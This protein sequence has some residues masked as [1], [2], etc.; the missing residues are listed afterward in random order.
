MRAARMP[1]DA[2]WNDIDH[3]DAHKDFTLDPA[4]FAAGEVA[5]MVADLHAHHQRYVIIV[6]PGIASAAGG[7]DYAPLAA[8][9]RH[10]VFIRDKTGKAP[11]QGRVWPGDVYFPD[12]LHPNASAYWGEQLAA[13]HERVPFDGVWLDMNE[14]S[15]FCDGDCTPCASHAPPAPSAASAPPAPSAAAPPPPP[16][17]GRAQPNG[18]SSSSG[19]GG[20]GGSGGG[21]G[22]RLS[23]REAWE[24]WRAAGALEEGEGGD[25]GAL[26]AGGGAAAAEGRCGAGGEEE[27]AAAA[28]RERRAG[29]Y[30]SWKLRKR[31]G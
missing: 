23:R 10:Q 19:G 13:F 3:M 25:V 14:P 4:T 24:R 30:A 2:Q 28:D 22:G 7:E 17:P 27:A 31:G 11:A 12:F 1:H 15:N 8:G 16:P 29:V 26:R 5:A 6:D 9:L 18:S 21:G 20:S